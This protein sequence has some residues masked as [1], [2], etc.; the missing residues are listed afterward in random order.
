MYRRLLEAFRR[1]PD[2]ISF[3]YFAKQKHEAFY[4]SLDAITNLLIARDSWNTNDVGRL[5]GLLKLS[6]WSNKC[7]LS[8]S[9]G[10]SQSFDKDPLAQLEK[11]QDRLLVNDVDL[12]VQLLTRRRSDG[13][14]IIDIVMDNA[15]FELFSDLCLAD[16]LV[17]SG[18][19]KKVRFRV[20]NCPWFVSDTTPSDVDWILNEMSQGAANK[21]AKQRPILI[22]YSEKWKEFLRKGTWT[23][24]AD[25][26]WTYPHDFRYYTL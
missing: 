1:S 13:G 21:D 2:L 17:E 12:V 26:F 4:G 7:D 11:F 10:A 24:T 8:I 19:A 9:A 25:P 14:A 16:Y 5:S 20:K 3:D 23:I 6:L 18:M 15:G 22:K